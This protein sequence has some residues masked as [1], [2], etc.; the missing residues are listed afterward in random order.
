MVAHPDGELAAYLSSLDRIADLTGTGEVSAILPGHGPVVPDA[1]A[2]VSY[3]RTHRVER[4]EQVRQFHADAVTVLPPDAELLVTGDVYPHQGFRVGESAW[5]VQYH[6]EVSADGFAV[7]AAKGE[8]NGELPSAAAL[9]EPIRA[10]EAGQEQVALAH[11]A[12]CAARLS[13]H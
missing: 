13:T 7:W 10:S 2:M 8:A 12:A 11:A 9:L 6:P 5:A 4:L 3:Y 1:S